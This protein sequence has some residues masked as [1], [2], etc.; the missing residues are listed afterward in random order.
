[1]KKS[2][3]STK[4]SKRKRA[5]ADEALEDVLR[6]LNIT[7]WDYVIFGDGSGS[8]WDREAG[9]AAITVERLTMERLLWDGCVNRGTVN[10]AEV[11]AYVQPMSWISARAEE[12]RGK[13]NFRKVP[14]EVH[15]VTDSQYVRDTGKGEGR[16]MVKNAALWSALDVFKRQGFIFRWHWI[17]RGSA[18]LNDL[19][20][21][22][23]RAARL[24]RKEAEL[25]AD[26]ERKSGKTVYQVNPAGR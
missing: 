2:N 17:R 12:A 16:T 4:K 14:H 8:N 1:M 9:W 10:F 22:Y 7:R 23:S 5:D 13:G 20:D 25:V 11:M 18:A 3:A 24:L 19:A 15:I 21:A 6:R 26:Q